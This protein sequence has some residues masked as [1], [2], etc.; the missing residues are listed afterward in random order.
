MI[1]AEEEWDIT[2]LSQG[3]LLRLSWLSGRA[4]GLQHSNATFEFS[5]LTEHTGYGTLELL[6]Y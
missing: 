3:L 1:D 2:S 6:P 4:E 5:V